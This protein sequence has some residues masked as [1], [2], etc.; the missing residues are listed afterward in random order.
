MTSQRNITLLINKK[1]KDDKVNESRSSLTATSMYAKCLVYGIVN[2][3]LVVTY[4][5]SSSMS[6][7]SLF[8]V[9]PASL[10]CSHSSISYWLISYSM[11]KK[12]SIL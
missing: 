7:S 4:M 2:I 8:S 9:A 10:S 5:V 11:T 3:I 6:F 12:I 1:I